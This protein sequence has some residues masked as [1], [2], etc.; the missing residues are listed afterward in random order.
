[1]LDQPVDP[2][3]REEIV[4]FV[5]QRLVHTPVITL[6]SAV[7]QPCHRSGVILLAGRVA[8]R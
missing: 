2:F 4:M 1:M 8:R 5:W 7:L 6:L 3:F